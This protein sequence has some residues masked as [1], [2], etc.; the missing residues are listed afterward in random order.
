MRRD[1]HVNLE[2]ASLFLYAAG[3]ENPYRQATRWLDV[4]GAYSVIESNNNTLNA[5]CPPNPSMKIGA[6]CPIMQLQLNLHSLELDTVI[7]R[8]LFPIPLLLPRIL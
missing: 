2:A 1:L 8:P 3:S 6:A 7:S 5:S 4:A